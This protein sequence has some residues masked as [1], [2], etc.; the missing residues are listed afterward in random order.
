MEFSRYRA[1]LYGTVLTPFLPWVLL[2]FSD[3]FTLFFSAGYTDSFERFVDILSY[4]F[5]YTQGSFWYEYWFWHVSLVLVGAAAV[6][7]WLRYT[8]VAGASLVFGSVALVRFSAGL[9]SHTS[10]STALPVAL[11]W[12]VLSGYL[13]YTSTPSPPEAESASRN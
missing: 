3:G 8:R 12:M 11:P 1:G 10:P 13:L 6:L 9:Q 4:T 2:V 5:L 7:A